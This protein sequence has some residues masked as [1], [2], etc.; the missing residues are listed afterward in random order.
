VLTYFY[1]G[2]ISEL[3]FAF[4]IVPFFANLEGTGEKKDLQRIA[5]RRKS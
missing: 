3:I 2:L 1:H 5:R 4:F